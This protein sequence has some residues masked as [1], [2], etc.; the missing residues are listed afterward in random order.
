MITIRKQIIAALLLTVTGLQWSTPLQ[1]QEELP[2]SHPL[3]VTGYGFYDFR[4]ATD[5]I[6]GGALM[7]DWEV[8]NTF[9][10]Y[11][12]AEYASINR[13]AAKLGGVATLLTTQKGQRLT[14]ENSYL[15]RHYPSF[16]RQ[17]FTGALQLGWRAR[18]VDLHL[19]LCNRYS[20]ALI[21]RAD[22][23]AGTVFEPMNVMFAIEGWWNNQTLP[24]QW[25]VGLRWS[26]YNDFVIERVA[27]WFFS[28]KGVYTLKDQTALYAEVGLHPVGSLNLTASYDG[29]FMHLGAVRSF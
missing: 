25:N 9:T 13:I 21:Q 4:Y 17:E 18:H 26:N 12:G 8:S 11:A 23:G 22:G 16:D 27:N 6:G 19:G 29:W 14:L 5:G 10:L 28:A 24:Q 7:A 3:T 2:K 1:G 15:W 20:A